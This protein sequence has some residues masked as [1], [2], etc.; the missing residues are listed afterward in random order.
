MVVVET[1]TVKGKENKSLIESIQ[2]VDYKFALDLTSR[3]IYL[4]THA[5]LK[6]RRKA[7]EL[8]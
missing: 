1:M 6:K 2:A 3:H 8:E 5:H 4:Y 7:R